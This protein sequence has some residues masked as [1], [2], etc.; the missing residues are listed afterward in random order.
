MGQPGPSVGG[1]GYGQGRLVLPGSPREADVAAGP[2]SL[3]PEVAL[4]AV[5]LPHVSAGAQWLKTDLHLHSPGV[6][7]FRLPDGSDV[8][9]ESG[10]A[11][12]ADR[13]VRRLVAAGIQVGAV[14]DYQGVRPEWFG[15][16]R[17][18]AQEQGIVLLPGA[19]MS[20][21]EGAGSGL[22]LLLVCNAET[23]PDLINDALRYVDQEGGSLFGHR[24]AHRD[25][26][27]RAPLRDTLRNLRKK[28]D[29]LVIA[30]H[31]RDKNGLLKEQ[32]AEQTALL[33]RDGLVDAIDMCED[34]TLILQGT[35]KLSREQL[36]SLAC[37]LS[38]DPKS[39]EEVGAKSLPDGRVRA[40]WLKLSSVDSS[41]LRLALH[42]PRT[43]MLTRPPQEPRH[44]RFLALEVDGSGFLSDLV[45]CFNDDLNTLI[46]GR[47]AGKSA[48]LETLRYTLDA[49]PF[50]DA[51]E[52]ESQ[53]RHA[54]GSGGRARLVLERPGN[55]GQ[56]YEVT[57]VLGQ[58]PRVR[59]AEG[60]AVDVHPMEIF[61]GRGAPMIL[62]QRE[63]QAVARNEDYRLRL[64]DEVIGAEVQQIR[65][66]L[67]RLLE[68]LRQNARQLRGVEERLARA[69]DYR[70]RLS[71][72]EA[73][74]RFYEAQGVAQK[75]RRHSG[76]LEDRTLLENAGERVRELRREWYEATEQLEED[77]AAVPASL[78]GQSEHANVLIDAASDVQPAV[79]DFRQVVA[80]AGELLGRIEERLR[81]AHGQ[82]VLDMQPLEEELRRV[83]QELSTDRLDSTALLSAVRTRTTLNPLV[84]AAERQSREREQLIERRRRQL[85]QLQ[86]LRRREHTLRRR[87]GEAVN[88]RLGGALRLDVEY[89]GNRAQYAR[90]LT[91]LFR[92]S[93]LGVEAIQQLI[94][95]EASDGVELARAV[96]QGSVAV[97]ERFDLS[98]AATARLTSWLSGDEGKDRLHQLELLAPTDQV[99]ISL[100]VDGR[101]RPLDELSAGQRATA[102]LLLLFAQPGRPL[103]LDQPEDDLDNRFVYEDV[104]QLLRA[105]K[106]VQD[107]SRRRQVV[108][109]THNANIP[110]NGD[111]ELVLSLSGENERC[112]I[113]TRAS[114]DDLEVRDHIRTV[115]EGGAEAFRRRA[116]KYGGIE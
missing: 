104:V 37:T 46:G 33:V 63:I 56:R 109:A 28:L 75:L 83:Q 87:A 16:L 89:L 24:L 40:T 81:A 26:D 79:D 57:R 71:R 43:R 29:C 70:E 95:P 10:R 85:D 38:G 112:S 116:E 4:N 80:R 11:V 86:D 36:D 8:A 17:E 96:C 64:L 93:R 103:V 6:H 55:P 5:S 82:L 39:L 61:G 73:E 106:G 30:A 3:T 100:T 50:S 74:I 35:N 107:P 15:I 97:R 66:D 22:H 60:R 99:R 1:D 78:T 69:D 32:G 20:V 51:S 14:T 111:A 110:V 25:I 48:I 18:R 27:L 115:L 67:R 84:E 23:P 90:D 2:L 9:S 19:E 102:L 12:I 108:V 52:R 45:T 101:P 105:E 42:D 77:V 7:T 68:D 44:V 41:A 76:L 114:I 49:R 88:E 98:D 59:D 65:S 62:L 92:G 91:D 58:A 13:Y 113:L 47:G 72:V 34:A 94:Q 31:A 54:L 21:R 53:V